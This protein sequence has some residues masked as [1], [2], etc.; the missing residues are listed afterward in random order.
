MVP[1]TVIAAAALLCAVAFALT[2]VIGP[3]WIERLLNLEADGGDGSLEVLLTV[4]PGVAA[5]VFGALSLRL[6]RRA[7]A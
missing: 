2:L 1:R 4:A 5:V 7:A 6:L 3:D